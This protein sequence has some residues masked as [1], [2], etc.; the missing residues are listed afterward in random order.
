MRICP[1]PAAPGPSQAPDPLLA[2]RPSAYKGLS[3]RL[4]IPETR[5]VA[6]RS[7]P[8]GRIDVV[9]S[10]A[11]P[12]RHAP[13][14]SLTATVAPPEQL[15]VFVDADSLMALTRF[16]GDTTPLAYLDQQTAALPYHLGD[17]GSVLVLGA[18]AGEELL[19]A[20]YHGV[21]SIDA[22]ELDPQL[23]DLLRHDFRDFSGAL[24]ER[25]EVR[26][27]IAEARSFATASDAQWDLVQL[28][29]MDSF[30]AAAAGVQALSESSLYTVEALEL[31][32]KRLAP[33][34]MLAITRWLRVPPRE[35]LK[36]FA[37]AA[38]ALERGGVERPGQH[39][40]MIR[41]WSTVTLLVRNGAFETQ[42]IAGLRAFCEQRGFDLVWY[43]GM[44]ESEANR[45][46][47][48]DRPYLHEG[49]RA[50]LGPDRARFIADYPF[51]I[52]PASDDQ[53]YFFRSFRWRLLPEI[54]SRRQQAAL[55]LLDSGYLVLVGTFAQSLLA[56][57]VLI[58]LPLL[59]LRRDPVVRQG[60]ATWRVLAYFVAL[61]L[62]FLFIEIAFIQRLTLF[63][64]HPL[65]AVAVVLAGFL[66]FAGIGSGLSQRLH[67]TQLARA[68][69][70][71]V[72]AIALL[73]TAY[74]L[75]LPSL[76]ALLQSLSMA[77]KVPLVLALVAPLGIAM[78]LPF[79]LGLRRV[80]AI[81]S[82]LVPLAWAVN[83]CA[84]VVAASLASLLAMHF[85][86]D[87]LVG[88]ALLAYLVA[89]A[90]LAGGLAPSATRG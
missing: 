82:D 4:N 81:T 65:G 18:G 48:F 32:M 89:A 35:S 60:I 83:G 6:T 45:F 47:R 64:G 72:A 75:L 2:L 57:V 58:L 5:V 79:P 46:N 40:A 90:S 29:L 84:S 67:D 56:S 10:P 66:V 23:G 20:I 50:L 43:P 16:A 76:L 78:G 73:C 74:L 34:G 88:M 87:L 30:T 11:V 71:A 53:P 22:V 8:L 15:G 21:A 39:L 68:T 55:T 28:A 26:L 49:A 62:G 12:F 24:Y 77:A 1:P 36:L 80:A 63:L 59:W 13:G 3:M 19:R 86:F 61:G 42:E 52:E 69:A 25:P 41:N 85:G 44:H 33:G 7:S 31:L 9:R 70:V 38:L 17:R 14:I 54:L 51:F 27:H 37:T